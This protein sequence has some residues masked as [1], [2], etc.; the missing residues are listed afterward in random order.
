MQS[1]ARRLVGFGF[2]A[3]AVIFMLAVAD[4]DSFP[5]N[6]QEKAPTA[7]AHPKVGLLLNDSRASLGYTLLAPLNS[8]NTYLIDMQGR[9]VRSWKSDCTPGANACLLE[10]GDLLRA[11]TIPNAPFFGGGAGGRVQKFTWGGK[12]TWDFAYH[13]A[14]KLPHHEIR[15]LPNGNVLMLVWNKKTAK[16]ATAA[17]RRPET[18]GSGFLLSCSVI[19]VKPTGKTTG[20]IVWAWHAWD[21]LI[22]D[23]DAKQANHGDVAAHPERIDV[24]FGEGALAAMIAKPAELAKLRAIGYV[25][26]ANRRPGRP[27][28]DWLHIN[29]VDYNAKL[30]Q[31]ILSVH[32]FNAIWIIDHSTTTAQAA[33]HTGGRSGMGGDLLYRW[34]NP[35]AYRAGAIK[36]QQLF[37]QHNAHWIPRHLPGGGHVLI[38]NNGMR[39]R[40]G[41]YS[42]VDELVLPVDSNG[43]YAYT[44]GKAFGPD[45]PIWSYAAPKRYEFFA[46]L[47]SGAQRLANGDT[48]ICSGPSG[49]VFEVTPTK[50]TVW[51][52]VNPSSGNR[53]PFGGPPPGAPPF[54]GP[55]RLGTLL[56]GFLQGCLGMKDSQRKRLDAVEKNIGSK[57]AKLLTAEQRK[58]LREGRWGFEDFPPPGQLL[59]ASVQE[60]LKL[61]KD[62]KAQLGAVQ[63]DADNE[64]KAILDEKQNKQLQQM[65]DMA[66]AF[67]GGPRP[68][69][70]PVGPPNGFPPG[71]PGGP[72]RGPRGG[73]RG[74]FGP[75]PGAAFGPAGAGLFRAPRYAPD[76]PA[77]AGKD[78]TPGKTIEELQAKDS[79]KRTKE[80]KAQ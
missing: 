51:K 50:E 20:T 65:K 13:S 8:T 71:P 58:R 25:G 55:P 21:H 26:G 1:T 52:Y 38:F 47:I 62:Q 35:R 24:N 79:P 59:S 23:F 45:K 9:V 4:P 7:K 53:P 36:D 49:T 77:F 74:G 29:S 32:E 54:G 19:E 64:R 72:P 27:Q 30:D 33:G 76:Y 44:P 3:L 73:R 41:S 42:S 31:I 15:A 11:G 56:P 17:G 57:L 28:Q 68:G 18:V 61:T 12:L 75:P 22:Q 78:L 34:G 70:F 66:K 48:L 67:A 80:K 46:M 60:R 63:K 10:N 14:T 2:L 16:E 37:G 6:A 5:A 40:G 43:H 39:R 69:A